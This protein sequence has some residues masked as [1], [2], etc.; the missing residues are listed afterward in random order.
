MKNKIII[1][2]LVKSNHIYVNSHHIYLYLLMIQNCSTFAAI[3]NID[4]QIDIVNV[5]IFFPF[6]KYLRYFMRCLSNTSMCCCKCH[7]IYY[8][9]QIK[10]GLSR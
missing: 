4:V 9:L 10:Y 7:C 8:I 3:F 1:Y 2:K 5:Y 6:L